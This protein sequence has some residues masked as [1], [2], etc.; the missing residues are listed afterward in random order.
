MVK[1]L[2]ILLT[3]IV[4]SFFFF[5]FV[6]TFF[7]AANTKMMMA[8]CGL[9]VFLVQMAQNRRPQM[10]T[11]LFN[12]SLMALAVSL[13]SFAT[14]V[15][16]S[17]P[18]N[19]Y[20]SYIVSM[21]T[22]LGAGYFA[23]QCIKYVHGKATFGLI[24]S[25]LVAVCVFQCLL[26]ITIDSNVN[27]KH[28]IDSILDGEGYMGKNV[29]R[30]YGLGCALD[31][32]GGRFSAV[33][34]LLV[35]YLSQL[36]KS[37]AHQT[38]CGIALL[39]VSYFLIALIGNM[40]GR[41]TILGV[42]LSLI[43]LFIALLFSF[44]KNRPQIGFLRWF[45]SIF[46]ICGI[47]AAT[48]LYH[49]DPRWE[50]N[51]KFGFEGFFSLVEKGKWEVSSNEQLKGTFITPDNTRCWIIG[52]GRMAATSIDPYYVG[53]TYKGFYMMTDVGYSRF[54]FYFGL[55]GLTCFSLFIIVAGLCCVKRL[56]SVKISILLVVL[57]NFM[58][59][60]KVSTDI[61]LV[62]CP[63]LCLPEE[64]DQAEEGVDVEKEE[65]RKSPAL[66]TA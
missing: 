46:L 37:D 48:V 45:F 24:V 28:F 49:T 65:M 62:L 33:L 53:K 29:D 7:T 20:L 1:A 4:T 52:D 58:I 32:A 22:W 15:Y 31:V 35:G 57:L 43:Y 59:W 8:A 14:M 63:L 34:V 11:D 64:N 39:V 3:G 44:G 54:L 13:A 55:I 21:W 56:P 23:V 36:V 26:A 12:L 16:N 47:V 27:V 41:T 40:I 61:F 60:F 50:H 17:T 66:P 10:R 2:A 18:D 25:Y 5:P 9:V 51:I 38:K 6:F 42:V 19:S 30:L